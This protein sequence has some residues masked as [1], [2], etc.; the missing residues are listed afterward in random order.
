[1]SKKFF[2]LDMDEIFIYIL[3]YLLVYLVDYCFYYFYVYFWLYLKEFIVGV[4]FLFD[5]GIWMVGGEFYVWLII[6]WIFFKDFFCF[7]WFWNCC[8]FVCDWR[9]YDRYDICKWIKKVKCLG[10]WLEFVIVV[11]DVVERY[12]SY[13]NLVVVKLFFGVQDDDEF[14]FLLVYLK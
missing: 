6:E 12:E 8:I 1:M 11:D 2:V 13:G 3:I 9:Y 7:F 4:L 5:V 14:F 10:Y